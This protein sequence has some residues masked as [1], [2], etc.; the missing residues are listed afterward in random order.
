MFRAFIAIEIEPSHE[1]R[2]FSSAIHNTGGQLKMV[3][4]DNLHITLKF[5][6]DTREEI[7]PEIKKII[8][9]SVEGRKPFVVKLTGAGAFPNLG[10]ISV[11]WAGM[12]E[13]DELARIAS[14]IDEKTATLGFRR[15]K[16]KFSAH[17][18]LARV[19]G[20]RNK[21]KLVD[22]IEQYKDEEFGTLAVDK[23]ILKKSVLTPDGP[24]YSDVEIVEL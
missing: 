21:D 19:R 15:E 1:L 17:I 11:I 16:R 18:T 8:A 14:Y 20:G 24:I 6:G 5:L 13:A 3:D 7:V 4:L 9:G 12:K 22:V 2:G 10:K 23:I